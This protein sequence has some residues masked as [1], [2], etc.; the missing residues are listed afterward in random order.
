MAAYQV[1]LNQKL[2]D[3]NPILAGSASAS[4]DNSRYSKMNHF[5]LIHFVDSGKGTLT[6]HG[7]TY[8]IHA[9]QAFVIPF[10]SHAYH[11]ADPDDPWAY[12]WIGLTGTLANKFEKIP[13]VFDIPKEV[14]SILCQPSDPRFTQESLAYRLSAELMFLYSL[15][16]KT[17]D[18]KSDYIQKIKDHVQMFYSDK[19]SIENLASS[20]GLSRSYLTDQFR[21]QTGY[22][23][24][25]YILTT[26]IQAA[27]QHLMQGCSVKEAAILCG[28]GDVS[29]FTKLFTRETEKSPT[30]W[31]AWVQDNTT[32]YKNEMKTIHDFFHSQENG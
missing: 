6:L 23:I 16:I 8:P 9:G 14:L 21:K 11:E 10:G 27:K 26:R 22:S 29:N 5:T 17:E 2:Q 13:P 30:E 31:I 7:S 3:L 1:L 25:Q 12:R 19:L 24:R 18:K 20:L 32:Q 4:L 28:I 15:L